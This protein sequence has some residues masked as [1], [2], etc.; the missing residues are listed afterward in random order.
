MNNSYH[1]SSSIPTQI[2]FLS[3]FCSITLARTANPVLTRGEE[4]TNLTLLQILE[5]AWSF[6]INT[7]LAV[8]LLPKH[9]L[10]SSI[11]CLHL[12][13]SGF[14]LIMKGC[15]ILTHFFLHL[16]GW[17]YK[18]SFCGSRGLSPSCKTRWFWKGGC[19]VWGAFVSLGWPHHCL[20]LCV[21]WGGLPVPLPLGF[22]FG[23]V[24]RFFFPVHN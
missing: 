10:W 5:E 8:G 18:V 11:F 7:I 16:I 12:T 15:W 22:L 3:F 23:L 20:H 9:L 14:I 19:Q 24:F 6:T 21:E 17:C 13:F 1:F 4:V 2:S